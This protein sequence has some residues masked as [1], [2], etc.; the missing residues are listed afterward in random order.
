MAATESPALVAFVGKWLTREPEMAIAEVFCPPERKPLYRAWGAL[1][2]EL[3]E[4]AFE[5][6]DA[7]VTEVKTAWWAE[8]LIGVGQGRH[9]HPL[10]EVL[11]GHSAPWSELG[12][13]LLELP[14]A[15]RRY[16]T[17]AEV[18]DSLMQVAR[19]VIAVE[20]ALFATTSGDDSARALVVH[21]LLQR[22]PHGLATEDQARIPMHLFARHG[23]SAAQLVAG[24]GDALLRD[25]ATE[26]QGQLPVVFAGA[27]A[28]RRSRTSFDRARLQRLASGRGFAEP[29]PLPTLW[30]AWRA[31]RPS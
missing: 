15:G 28:F 14:D 31:A 23:L 9:R 6:S 4:A 5:L 7:R 18:I 16:D 22:L 8:E 25:W 30:R 13:S 12:R 11:L 21:W 17:T 2:H 10:T 3:R 19:S 26:L 27:S 29:P 1:L 24:Q 20:S